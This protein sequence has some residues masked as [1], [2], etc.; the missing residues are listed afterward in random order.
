LL[1]GGEG[2]T[3]ARAETRAPAIVESSL[4]EI[5]LA[6][7][8]LSKNLPPLQPGQAFG[9]GEVICLAFRRD[10]ALLGPVDPSSYEKGILKVA[11]QDAVFLARLEGVLDTGRTGFPPLL[12]IKITVEHPAVADR[13]KR[14][15]LEFLTKLP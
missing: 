6:R 9:A 8:G 11:N 7:D 2:G 5:R 15:R 4:A 12:T 3:A 1:R 10:G 14:R 13:L